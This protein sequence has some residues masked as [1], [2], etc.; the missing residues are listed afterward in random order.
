MISSHLEVCASLQFHSLLMQIKCSG[1]TAEMLK[2]QSRDLIGAFKTAA[3]HWGGTLLLCVL[4]HR[5]SYWDS[6]VSPAVTSQDVCC[7]TS[8]LHKAALGN[9]VLN[10]NSWWSCY[11]NGKNR[12]CTVRILKGTLWTLQSGSLS[13]NPS[14]VYY[15]RVTKVV[16]HDTSAVNNPEDLFTSEHITVL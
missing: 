10:Q 7:V 1:C 2:C 8:S 14:F 13:I 6:T 11:W 3:F 16:S 4:I 5:H 12:V 9:L 15:W